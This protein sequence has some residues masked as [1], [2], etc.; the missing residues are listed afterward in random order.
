MAFNPNELLLEKIRSVEEYDPATMEMMGRYTQIESPVLTTTADG[1]Q[2]TDAMGAEIATIYNAQQ[3]TFSFTN[4]L[5]SLDLMASQFAS[6]KEVADEGK[7]ITTYVSEILTI[8]GLVAKLSYVP[9]GVEGAEVQFAKVINANNTY[10]KT[11]KVNQEDQEGCFVVDASAKTL[12]FHTGEVKTGDKVFVQY[13]RESDK[14]VRVTKT[15]DGV[16]EVRTLLIHALFHDPCNINLT[17]AG[18]IYV[19]RAQINPES[20][21]LNLT[22]D[23]K[24]SAEYRLQKPYCDTG[25]A[26]L[27]DIIVTED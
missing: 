9:T 12:T 11:F 1:T 24:H 13:T 8:N 26:K 25:D 23:G 17:Y 21:E 27:F 19:P 4:S 16:P 5:H 2:V 7:K 3:G 22:P 14:A 20:V 10:G 15:T 6:K 18:V